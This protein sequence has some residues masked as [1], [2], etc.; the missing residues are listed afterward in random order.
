MDITSYEARVKYIKSSVARVSKNFVKYQ[1]M[2]G[3]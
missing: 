1:M 3:I 2:F